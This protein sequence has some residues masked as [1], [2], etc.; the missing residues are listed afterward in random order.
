MRRGIRGRGTAGKFLLLLGNILL[1]VLIPLTAVSVFMV[2]SGLYE[3]G[4]DIGYIVGIVVI[5]LIS[6]IA[7]TAVVVMMRQ[8][9]VKPMHLCMDAA[10]RLALGDFDVRLDPQ[11]EPYSD[12]IRELMVDMNEMADELGSIEMLRKDFVNNFSHEFKTPIVSLNGFAKLLKSGDITPQQR[13]EYIDI[14]VEESDR[15]ASLS[16]DVLAMSKIESQA[17]LAKRDTVDISESIRR[18][19]VMAVSKWGDKNLDFDIDLE[20]VTIAGDRSLLDR[21]WANVIDNACKFSPEGGIVKISLHA[22]SGSVYFQVD[23]QGCGVPEEA[24]DRIFEKF[25]QGDTSHA[26]QGNGLGLPM[27]KKAVELHGGA[28]AIEEAEGGGTRL[29]V[30]LPQ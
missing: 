25:Y 13:D 23:D 11:A 24:R 5:V 12:E 3:E 30:S 17:L 18:T 26:M 19:I 10:K 6:V 1:I 28:V 9:F 8:Y 22:F 2:K 21:V 15:L 29:I 16:G 20:E 14:I 7:A 27:V 4:G